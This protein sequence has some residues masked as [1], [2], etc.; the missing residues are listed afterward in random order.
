MS[1]AVVVEAEAGPHGG[2]QPQMLHQRLA[3]MMPGTQ[4]DPTLPRDLGEVVGMQPRDI[5]GDDGSARSCG[6]RQQSH[7]GDHG[8]RGHR[9]LREI[10]YMGPD[11]S[12]PGRSEPVRRRGKAQRTGQ[13]GRTRLEALAGPAPTRR[14]R[15]A[16]RSTMPPPTSRGSIS[17]SRSGRPNRAPMPV[18]PYILWAEKARNRS[19]ARPT[20]TGM[21]PTDWAAS[22]STGMPARRRASRD[23]GHRVLHPEHIG[24]LAQRD[25][26]GARVKQAV[27][28]L[29]V[30]RAVVVQFDEPQ[31][32]AALPAD[33]L[34]GQEIGVV[35]HARDPDLDR[36]AATAGAASPGPPG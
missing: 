28:A 4:R 25:Q 13:I 33:P 10:R 32:G 26:P 30:Q 15:R 9:P 14:R 7:S 20:S 27:G 21:V 6:G 22:T 36:R 19:P 35:L 17:C 3:A 2:R 29:Q 18:G 11:P 31:L 5:E 16:T 24:H 23:R 1:A 12:Y 8:E 34:P